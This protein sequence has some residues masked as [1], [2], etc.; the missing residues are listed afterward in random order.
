MQ[1]EVNEESL[2]HRINASLPKGGFATVATFAN[3]IDCHTATIW[4]NARRDRRVM[5]TMKANYGRIGEETHMKWQ[6]GVFV[7]E[8]SE[9]GLDRL[10]AGAK[11][12][13]VFMKLLAAFTAQGRPVNHVGG[14]R[15]APKLFAEHPDNEGMTKRALKAA[16]EGLLAA[17]QIKIETEGP[18]SRRTSFIVEAGQ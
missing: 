13:R 10:A 9:Q 18:A 16:M 3:H 11:A 5:T 4:R 7:A 14:S 1:L 12:Q 6:A 8:A 17:E 15:Y 2:G